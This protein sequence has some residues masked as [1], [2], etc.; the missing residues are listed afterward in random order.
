[1]LSRHAIEPDVRHSVSKKRR[2][3]YRHGCAVNAGPST[4]FR[5]G[6]GGGKGRS[7]A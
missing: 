5:P 6:R 4:Q 7:P 3:G 1:L 2:S